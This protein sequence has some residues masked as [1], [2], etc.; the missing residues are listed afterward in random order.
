MPAAQDDR[1]H[2]RERDQHQG[3]R[4][5]APEWPGAPDSALLCLGAWKVGDEPVEVAVGLRREAALEAI[6]E[7]VCVEASFNVVP[8]DDLRDRVAFT[9]ADSERAIT[10]AATPVVAVLFS[11]GI[12]CSFVLSSSCLVFGEKR[13]QGAPRLGQYS[14]GLADLVGAAHVPNLHGRHPDLAHLCEQRGDIVVDR[15]AHLFPGR[16]EVVAALFHVSTA[17]CGETVATTPVA[18]LDAH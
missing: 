13:V 9:V 16:G 15:V 11:V 6:L 3:Q 2:E 1:R 17:G 5:D 18:L 4:G 7:L 12:S 8:T 10:R 14:V